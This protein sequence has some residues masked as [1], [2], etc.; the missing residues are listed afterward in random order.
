MEKYRMFLFLSWLLTDIF[1]SEGVSLWNHF[2]LFYCF[3]KQ[4]LKVFCKKGI[5][6]IFIKFAKRHLCQSFY[7]NIV[8]GLSPATLLKKRPWHKCFSVTFTKFLRKAFLHNTSYFS[9]STLEFCPDKRTL[10]GNCNPSPS[11][12]FTALL[13]TVISHFPY[14]SA[15]RK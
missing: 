11:P 3:Q 14:R 5:L 15:Q 2:T 8:A 1:T 9:I 12:W 4:P 6:I 10:Q 13:F 7:S